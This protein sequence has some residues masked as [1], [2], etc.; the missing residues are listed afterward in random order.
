MPIDPAQAIGA[1]L[2]D[3]PF[4]WTSSDVLLYHLAIGAGQR[5]DD[6]VDPA[7]LRLTL[8]DDRLGVLPSFGVVAP[9]FHR[10]M[11][12]NL[13]IPGID[14]DLTQVLHG[15]QSV[16][17]HRPIPASGSGTL[18]SRVTDIW[19][20]GKAAVIVQSGTAVSDDGEDLWTVTSS[21]FVR[22]EGGWGGDRGPSTAVAVP[23][24]A[25]DA[26]S[27]YAVSPQQ[28]L[29]YRLCGDRN[30]LHAD[31]AFAARAGFPRPILHGLCSYGI[32]L[33]EVTD[34]LLDRD[35]SRVGGFAA[36]FSG[37]VFPGESIR[38]EAWDGEGSIVVRA[39]IAGGERDGSPVLSDCVVTKA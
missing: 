6:P 30:P 27:T 29:L 11:P 37:I 4:S 16:Q 15:S 5:P 19:D 14:I 34:L 26:V 32:V 28:A 36:R 31:P 24:R 3:L 25:A 22:G 38:V 39:T 2:P 17:V 1:S 12:P 33:R 21:I 20:K 9:G 23:E 10:T 8:D 18:H 13:A 35:P 7:A